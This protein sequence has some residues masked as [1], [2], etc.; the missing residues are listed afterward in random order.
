MPNSQIFHR[1]PSGRQ[2]NAKESSFGVRS[3]SQLPNYYMCALSKRGYFLNPS[4]L[5]Y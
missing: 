5:I 4:F 2:Q 1:S 3:K